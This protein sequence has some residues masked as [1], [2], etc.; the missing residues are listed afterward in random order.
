MG[1]NTGIMIHN[2][3]LH[4]IRKD[5]KFGERLVEA[6]LAHSPGKQT[7]TSIVGGGCVISMSHSNEISLIAIGGNTGARLA[8][9][10][11]NSPSNAEDQ[12]KALRIAAMALG[13]R[14]TKSSTIGR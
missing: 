6:V 13:Y 8:V 4:E 7:T 5:P 10:S 2:D 9:V 12:L 3:D 14:L 11:A 1:Y